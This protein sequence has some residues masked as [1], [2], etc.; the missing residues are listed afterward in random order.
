MLF[1]IRFVFRF[2][3]T[4]EKTARAAATGK[5]LK[6]FRHLHRGQRLTPTPGPEL[7]VLL[8]S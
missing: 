1:E 6:L 2:R 3:T 4:E 8:R 5:V 7:G